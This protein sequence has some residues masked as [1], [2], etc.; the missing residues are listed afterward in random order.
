[1]A[2]FVSFQSCIKCYIEQET[3]RE[4]IDVINVEGDLE[5]PID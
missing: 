5:N 1:V 4:H 3:P 2:V